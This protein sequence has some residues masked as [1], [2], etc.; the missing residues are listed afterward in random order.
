MTDDTPTCEHH[1]ENYIQS[2]GYLNR[3]S[4]DSYFH[5]SHHDLVDSE[6]SLTKLNN[7]VRNDLEDLKRRVHS[8]RTDYD[9]L[10]A[11][12]D[13]KTIGVLPKKK[14]KP[15]NQ[16]PQSK[17]DF[18]KS[19]IKFLDGQKVTNMFFKKNVNRHDIKDEAK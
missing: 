7:N 16:E 5:Q 10:L 17:P 15:V 4:H 3:N 9:K 19:I 2:E 8:M 1:I 12:D 6:K 14:F 11:R 18:E 13:G